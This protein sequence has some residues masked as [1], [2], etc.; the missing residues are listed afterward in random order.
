M[1][2]PDVADLVLKADR[3]LAAAEHLCAS[4]FPDFAVSRAYYAMF[5]AAEALLLDQD[6]SFPKHSTVISAFG[7]RFVRCRDRLDYSRLLNQLFLNPLDSSARMWRGSTSS[8]FPR[9]MGLKR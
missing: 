7:Q 9:N 2:T 6:L 4:G 5:Y 3:S 1:T 8:T